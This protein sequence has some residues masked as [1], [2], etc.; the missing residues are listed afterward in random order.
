MRKVISLFMVLF[1]VFIMMTLNASEKQDLWVRA[2]SEKN[3]ES[4]LL[5]LEQFNDKYNKDKRYFKNLFINL[6]KTAFQLRNFDKTIK[7]GETAITAENLEQ[8]YKLELYLY[9]ANA[10]NVTKSDLDKAYQYAGMVIDLSENMKKGF[11]EGAKVIE[12]INK[13][14][15]APSLRIQAVI[16]YS[17]G[18]ENPENLKKALSKVLD[19]FKIDGSVRSSDKVFSYAVAL[20]KKNKSSIDDSLNAVL[21]L[22]NKS[23]ESNPR[24]LNLISHWYVVKKDKD[25]AVKYLRLLYDN[26]KK[27]STAL[28]LGQLLYK[29]SP[30]KALEYFAESFVLSDEDK[31]S[32]AYKYLQQLWFNQVAKGK[33][34]K[35]QDEGFKKLIETAKTR[36]KSPQDP[37]ENSE[38]LDSS[39]KQTIN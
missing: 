9:L 28:K 34:A 23:E 17:K 3:L 25:N 8:N 31:E 13:S 24:Y 5:Y 38:N 14:F 12:Q 19:A 33:P 7:Y 4:R 39:E 6:T 21:E 15:E 29:T 1:T 10:Y 22:N 32:R 20:Y 11:K 35:E 30:D 26:K 36:L 2:I 16:L 27:N 37:E 18:N